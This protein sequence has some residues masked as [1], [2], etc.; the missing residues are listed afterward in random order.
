MPPSQE[1]KTQAQHLGELL[2]SDLSLFQKAKITVLWFIDVI[3]HM[4]RHL[5]NFAGALGPWV[6]L[7]VFMV[8]FLE[9]GVV[10]FP[11]LPGDSFLFALGALTAVESAVLR[12]DLLLVLTFI[13]A[14]T[15]DGLNYF[16]GKRAGPILFSGKKIKFLNETHLTKAQ[17]FYEKYGAKAIV[18]ARFAP[19]IRTFAPF[20][21]GVGSMS[22][23]RFITYNIA[24]GAV[25]IVTF[26]TAGH[27]FGN[28]PAVKTNFHYVIFGIIIVS[29]VPVA[30]EWWKAR[31]EGAGQLSN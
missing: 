30:V 11:F 6:Y 28:L 18:I 9:T 17:K 3:L 25:W 12:L 15:G 7:L 2:S 5:N 8:I 22:Y 1:T 23:G 14:V 13:A 27:Y 4:D 21:A 26:L 10:I 19:I 24:G 16:I 31:A 29:L 20:V